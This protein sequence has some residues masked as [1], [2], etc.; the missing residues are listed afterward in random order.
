MLLDTSGWLCYF[1]ASDFQF[2]E[3]FPHG[4]HGIH[5]LFRQVVPQDAHALSD[6][7]LHSISSSS[8]VL[9][10][11]PPDAPFPFRDGSG[12]PRSIRAPPEQAHRVMP[13]LICFPYIKNM[14][15]TILSAPSK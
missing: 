2:D 9:P 8:R 1:D 12:S 6:K 4:Q 11:S 10:R 7:L 15:T 14:P 13:Q 3:A 5:S